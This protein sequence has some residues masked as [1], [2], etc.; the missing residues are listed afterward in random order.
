MINTDQLTH[1]HIC[2][3][4]HTFKHNLTPSKYKCYVADL[5]LYN[6]LNIQRVGTKKRNKLIYNK[7]NVI[8][9]S[10]QYLIIMGK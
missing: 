10:K 4:I 2:M 8:T 9:G 7:R 5:Q 6:S 1:T 3:Y